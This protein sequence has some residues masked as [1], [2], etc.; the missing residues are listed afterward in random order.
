MESLISVCF[1]IR[2]VSDRLLRNFGRRLAM[3]YLSMST[4]RNF[5]V[6]GDS[7]SSGDSDIEVT[8]TIDTEEN[9]LVRISNDLSLDSDD[10]IDDGV[11][12]EEH[13]RINSI[14]DVRTSYGRNHDVHINPADSSALVS[15]SPPDPGTGSLFSKAET[16]RWS[17]LRSSLITSRRP[18]NF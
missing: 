13:R 17:S 9:E 4:P 15:S 16:T 14:S 3:S 1:S 2:I 12:N 6:A 8:S 10:S 11:S 5:N 7:S 18:K